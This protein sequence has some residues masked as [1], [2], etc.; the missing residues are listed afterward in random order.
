M[1]GKVC[2]KGASTLN[3]DSNQFSNRI[4]QFEF[5]VNPIASTLCCAE[6]NSRIH[7]D[8]KWP[9]LH[10]TTMAP[11]SDLYFSQPSYCFSSWAD[12]HVQCVV[13]RSALTVGSQH[14]RARHAFFSL[15]AQSAIA[16]SS[17]IRIKTTSGSG[18]GL[19]RIGSGL[20]KCGRTQTRFDLVQCA[21]GAQ[22]GRVLIKKLNTW[23]CALRNLI[24]TQSGVTFWAIWLARGHMMH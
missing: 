18:L 21:L 11:S 8:F 17:S 16:R 15:Y 1:H 23:Q 10:T 9:H 7:V 3:P 5:N 24:N 14:E 20:G 19:I 13:Q 22:C 12:T 6:P 2:S 4:A